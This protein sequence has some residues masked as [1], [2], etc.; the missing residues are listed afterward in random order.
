M[1]FVVIR[2]ELSV[3]WIWSKHKWRRHQTFLSI[4]LNSKCCL[5][6]IINIYCNNVHGIN[7]RYLRNNCPSITIMYWQRSYWGLLYIIYPSNFRFLL[8]LSKINEFAERTACFMFQAT[9]A[10]D[11]GVIHG[12]CNMLH[13]T[14]DVSYVI[15]YCTQ[16][17]LH[18]YWWWCYWSSLV[19]LTKQS[20]IL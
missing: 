6:Q 11:L 14:I 15:S 8:D 19:C 18:F 7:N 3:R 17:I 20:F 2:E 1:V 9:F 13:T 16:Q 12:R 10:E 5:K 4:N